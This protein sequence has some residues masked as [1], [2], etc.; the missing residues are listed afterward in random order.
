MLEAGDVRMDLDTHEVT[1]AG[2]PLELTVKE[3]ELLRVS[4]SS[5]PPA[6]S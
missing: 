3:F 5:A 1:H 6:S 2:E 4:S